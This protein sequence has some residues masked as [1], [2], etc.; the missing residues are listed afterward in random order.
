ME[1]IILVICAMCKHVSVHKHVQF[2]DVRLEAH[3][4]ANEHAYE[5]RGHLLA[6]ME[7][8]EEVL[9]D[10]MDGALIGSASPAIFEILKTAEPRPQLVFMVSLVDIVTGKRF[11]P[12]TNVPVN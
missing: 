9:H 10:M 4:A 5:N 12:D 3:H 6:G 11:H 7:I 2:A 8:G 1:K